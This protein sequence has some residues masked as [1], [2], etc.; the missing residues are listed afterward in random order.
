MIELECLSSDAMCVRMQDM[1]KLKKHV[2]YSGRWYC[3]VLFE[4]VE[5][6]ADHITGSLYKD[7]KCL[8]GQLV[9]EELL[10]KQE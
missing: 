6:L 3:K 1:Q 4:E 8:T 2:K 10:E 7:G 9:I 5:Y